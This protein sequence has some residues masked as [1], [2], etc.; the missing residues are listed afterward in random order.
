MAEDPTR[1]I[2]C[3]GP[4]DKAFL[5]K[6]I[7]NRKISP[8]LIRFPGDI[9]PNAQHKKPRGRNAFANHIYDMSMDND[10]Q[11]PKFGTVQRL[12]VVSDNDDDQHKSF[13]EVLSELQKAFP[14]RQLPSAVNE[15]VSGHPALQ[16]A[17]WPLDGSPGT[18]E[19]FCVDAA[20]SACRA[21][22]RAAID[23]FLAML[24]LQDKARIEG[25]ATLLA[26]FQLAGVIAARAPNPMM[27]LRNVLADHPEIIDLG[28]S[29]FNPLAD[30]LNDFAS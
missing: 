18:L 13:G 10:S 29:S 20:K 11:K 24:P 17:M 7:A 4:T 12:L 26:K 6:L 22:T 16:V 2:L 19:T 28:H 30:L 23:T 8:V 15:R 21:E 3:E 27:W 25:N 9:Q 1:M 14:D 5:E